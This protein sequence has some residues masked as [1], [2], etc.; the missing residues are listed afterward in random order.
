SATQRVFAFN[1]RD[2]S[3]TVIDAKNGQ[4]LGTIELGGKPEYAAAD[5]MGHVFVN[6]EDKNTLVKIDAHKLT[7]LDRWPVAPGETAVSLA[8][9][10]KHRRLFVGCRNK[11]VVIVNADNG[12]VVDTQP[13]GARVDASAFDPQAGLVFCS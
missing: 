2:N 7:V 12:K 5:G 10:T 6:L 1:G 13:I 8:I 3:A 11:L 9:D 4:V